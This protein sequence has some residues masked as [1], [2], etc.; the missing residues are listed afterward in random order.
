LF[1]LENKLQAKALGADE[2]DFVAARKEIENTISSDKIVIYTY[3]LSPFSTE[4]TAVLD[5]IGAQYKEVKLGLEW[6][7]LDK[8]KST[9]RAELLEMTGQSSLPHVF[10]DG[11]HV[12]GL[13][14]GNADGSSPGL[15][16][17]KESGELKKMIA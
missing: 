2:G 12:G 4:A 16:G 11:K 10:I 15:A 5:E 8:D 17:L 9:I 6:F 13:F 3:G 14:T 7:L 1:K